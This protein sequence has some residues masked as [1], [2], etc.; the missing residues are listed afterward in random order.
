MKSDLPPGFDTTCDQKKID[1]LKKLFFEEYE[2]NPDLYDER[3]VD[4]LRKSDLHA[5]R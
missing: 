5:T 2:K 1:E 3:D 4:H